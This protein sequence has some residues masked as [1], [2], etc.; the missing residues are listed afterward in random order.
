MALS[1]NQAFDHSN[2]HRRAGGDVSSMAAYWHNGNG[3]ERDHR[4]ARTGNSHTMNR[5][6]RSWERI[7][8]SVGFGML[9]FDAPA[10]AADM[11]LKAPVLKAV[12]DWTGFYVG[13]AVGYGGG[14]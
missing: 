4:N 11:P 14:S 3:D 6:N 7:I 1:L 12:Y 8:A 13:G 10:M 5:C 9:M 2:R